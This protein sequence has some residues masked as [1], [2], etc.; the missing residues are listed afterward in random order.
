VIAEKDIILFDGVCNLCT[1][2]VQF[3][4]KRDTNAHF[5]FASLQ[6]N[7][8]REKLRILGIHPSL[9]TIILL[10]GEKYFLRSSAALE[11]VRKLHGIW[12]LLYVFKIIP[13]FVRNALYNII[14]NSRYRIFGKK[15][16][17][18]V[19]SPKWKDRFLE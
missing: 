16:V 2:A 18:M 8:A 12:P 11:I 5:V 1:G 17:C 15:D 14:A 6:S 4:L 3:I 13:P 10:R 7:V 19:P 9:D